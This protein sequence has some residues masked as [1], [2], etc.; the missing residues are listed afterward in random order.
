M[1]TAYSSN[2]LRFADLKIGE[3]FSFYHDPDVILT[4]KTE[5]TYE[6]LNSHPKIKGKVIPHA[7][8]YKLQ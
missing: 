6:S 7:Y 3:S 4:K 5:T 2:P 1:Y 8:V